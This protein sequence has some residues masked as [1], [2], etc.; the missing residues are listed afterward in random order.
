VI[1]FFFLIPS[2]MVLPP[3][4]SLLASHNYRLFLCG[5]LSVKSSE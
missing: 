2:F 4:A 1:E 3:M 5:L